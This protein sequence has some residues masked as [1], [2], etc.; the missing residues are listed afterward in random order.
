[1]TKSNKRISIKNNELRKLV[2]W[3]HIGTLY[4]QGG[5]HSKEIPKI[6]VKYMKKLNMNPYNFCMFKDPESN[7]L[8][9][10]VFIEWSNSQK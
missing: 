5:S 3:A 9:Y 10:D 1:M 4:S 7:K 6:I 8:A 2:F